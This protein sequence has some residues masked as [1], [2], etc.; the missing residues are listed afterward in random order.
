MDNFWN[1]FLKSNE[2]KYRLLRTITQ[3][4]IGVVVAYLDVIVGTMAI[5]DEL[6]PMIVALVMAVLS[7]LMS[8]LGKSKVDIN[9]EFYACSTQTSFNTDGDK[10][11]EVNEDEDQNGM[12]EE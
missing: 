1:R 9:T 11:F 6:R 4:V 2:T 7:P 5:P 8:E 12:S 10:M 3:G